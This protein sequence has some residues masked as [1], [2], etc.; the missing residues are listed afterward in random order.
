MSIACKWFGKA[1]T[2]RLVTKFVEYNCGTKMVGRIHLEVTTQGL[3]GDATSTSLDTYYDPPRTTEFEKLGKE[4]EKEFITE[5][6]ASLKVNK[7]F[8][9]LSAGGANTIFP[10]DPGHYKPS[11]LVFSD[12]IYQNL[13]DIPY[14]RNFGSLIEI[15]KRDPSYGVTVYQLPIFG[16][17][18]YGTFAHPSRLT[19]LFLPDVVV[20]DKEAL[21]TKSESFRNNARGML[22]SHAYSLGSVDKAEAE[23]AVA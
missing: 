15:F 21:A 5:W 1:A 20:F 10:S 14:W 16:N 2:A 13:R 18:T 19:V 3:A 23:K 17:L 8:G 7:T 12:T 22:T 6:L 11:A 4:N 9:P